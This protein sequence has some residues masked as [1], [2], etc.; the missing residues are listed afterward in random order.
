[1]V[2]RKNK[3]SFNPQDPAYKKLVAG[4]TQIIQRPQLASITAKQSYEILYQFREQFLS[5][6]ERQLGS[7]AKQALWA[8]RVAALR[9]SGHDATLD[10]IIAALSVPARHY[11]LKPT[12]AN[13][14]VTFA[15]NDREHIVLATAWETINRAKRQGDAV[16][17][18]VAEHLHEAIY[19]VVPAENRL[20]TAP[21]SKKG[22]G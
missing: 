15:L 16:A 4:I 21:P 13:A 3:G 12:T 18:Q 2:T 9:L 7:D 20:K 1:M 10:E 22:R 8:D 11:A 6:A 19:A 14:P 17:K 5:K